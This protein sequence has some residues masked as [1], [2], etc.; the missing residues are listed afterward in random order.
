M[1]LIFSEFVFGLYFL[2][3]Y[4]QF[5]SRTLLKDLPR[6]LLPFCFILFLGIWVYLHTNLI[7]VPIKTIHEI[8]LQLKEEVRKRHLQQL[9]PQE[10]EAAQQEGRY[11]RYYAYLTSF[12]V[13][14]T[15][16]ALES[17]FLI[18]LM[19]EMISDKF[20]STRI[21]LLIFTIVII[22]VFLII[23]KRTTPPPERAAFVSYHNRKTRDIRSRS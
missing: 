13:G 7:E 3:F 20:D 14:T 5:G 8:L 9:A 23:G 1:R 15:F 6:L 19:Q 10:S 21:Y 4:L 16:I 18:T 2:E 17:Y 12:V 22:P 11:T